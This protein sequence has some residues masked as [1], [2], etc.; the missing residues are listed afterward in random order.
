MRLKYKGSRSMRNG[1][2]FA[3]TNPGELP[4]DIEESTNA[5]EF[6]KMTHIAIQINQ[7]PSDKFFMGLK[8]YLCSFLIVHFQDVRTADCIS[9]FEDVENWWPFQNSYFPSTCRFFYPPNQAEQCSMIEFYGG[10]QSSKFLIKDLL[11]FDV[12]IS[13]QTCLYLLGMK[14]I[15]E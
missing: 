15:C 14:I 4:V 11:S 6:Y 8:I 1:V 5:V 7:V 2:Y 10:K 12:I 13:C 3:L 9:K